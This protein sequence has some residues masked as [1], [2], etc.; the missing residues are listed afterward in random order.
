MKINRLLKSGLVILF[1]LMLSQTGS[2]QSIE[3]KGVDKQGFKGLQSMNGNGYYV[4]CFEGRVGKGKETKRI[5]NIYMLTNGL[6]NKVTIKLEL[7]LGDEIED[8]AYNNGTFMLVYGNRYKNYRVL[9]TYDAN[10]AELSTKRL[11]DIP[12]RLFAK[13]ASIIPIGTSDFLLLN[14][15]KEKKVGYSLERYS[16][17]LESLFAVTE[18][19][20][21]QKLFPVDVQVVGNR[22]FVLEFLSRGYGDDFQYFVHAYDVANGQSTGKSLLASTDGKAFGYATFIR[23]DGKGGVLTGGMFFD[24]PETR[25]ANSDGFFAARVTADGQLTFTQ[26]TWKSVQDQVKDQSTSTLWG[27]KTKTFVHDIVPVAGGLQVIGQNYRRGDAQLAGEKGGSLMGNL[28]KASSFG[29]SSADAQPYEEAFTA[30]EFVLFGFD[31]ALNFTGVKKIDKP[32]SIYIVKKSQNESE[33]PPVGI[34]KGLNLA[35]ILNNKGMLPYRFTLTKND[36]QYL[37]YWLESQKKVTELLCFTP[38][39][40]AAMDTVSIDVTGAELKYFQNLAA[41]MNKGLLGKMNK[42]SDNLSGGSSDFEKEVTLKN[43]DDPNDYRAKSIN[44]RVV[45][46]NEPGR[47]LIYDF[48]PEPAPEG[49]KRGFFKEME[50]LAN[51]TLKIW[52]LDV[53]AK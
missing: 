23:P 15:V 5:F 1:Y 16:P 39:D 24:E 27:G 7:L 53:P 52:Y 32:N 31:D 22:I 49:E 13:P 19:P 4:Q 46:S 36:K 30:A 44:T 11:E 45:I 21:K 2:A 28:N 48:I 12:Y 33:K 34:E 14:Y 43:S 50:A 8:A 26:V 37:V 3:L 29:G 35:N 41:G 20:E 25:K 42:M 10:G 18:T 51:G 17:K 47:M 38:I 6:E 9:K 40:A